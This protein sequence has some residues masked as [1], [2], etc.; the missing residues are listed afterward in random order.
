MRAKIVWTMRAVDSGSAVGASVVGVS[1]TGPST[2]PYT[3]LF[4]TIIEQRE[5]IAFFEPVV[6]HAHSIDRHD[7]ARRANADAQRNDAAR[8]AT[9]AGVEE[10]LDELARQYSVVCI[11]DHMRCGYATRLA[12]A[13]M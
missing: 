3:T 7:W 13:A 12:R 6:F 2:G 9:E 10:F 8:L 11:S 4:E 1:F 5:R